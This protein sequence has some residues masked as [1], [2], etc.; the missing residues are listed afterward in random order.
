MEDDEGANYGTYYTEPIDNLQILYDEWS[1]VGSG[2][3]GDEL[4]EYS[5]V[6]WFTGDDSITT[7]TPQEESDLTLFLD[8]GGNLFISGKNIGQDIGGTSTFYSNYLKAVHI[9]DNAD[10]NLL[11]GVPG[12]PISNNLSLVITGPNGAGNAFSEDKI[13]PLPPSTWVFTYTSAGGVGAIK[14]DPGSYRVVYFS[15]PFEAI[16]GA[17]SFASRDTVMAR[18]LDWICPAPV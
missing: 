8:G 6:I 3:P 14:H 5:C 11:T 13:S 10:D 4:S 7:L 1:V 16:S 9:Q 17:G 15:F 18:V 2:A 12:D